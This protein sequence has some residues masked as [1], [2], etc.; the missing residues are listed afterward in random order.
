MTDNIRSYFREMN[1]SE[2]LADDMMIVPPEKIRFLSADELVRYGLVF[3]D[4]AAAEAAD[5]REAKKLGISRTEYMRR[6]SG[7]RN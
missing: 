5:L 2:R 7:S 6:R 4:S 1:V 3:I